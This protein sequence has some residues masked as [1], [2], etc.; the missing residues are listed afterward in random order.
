MALHIVLYPYHG[1]TYL[2]RRGR[3]LIEF[4]RGI[5]RE[6]DHLVDVG[7]GGRIK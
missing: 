5:L 6:R 1:T 2:W 4:V 3:A 7:V